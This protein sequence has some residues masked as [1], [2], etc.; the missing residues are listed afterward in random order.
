MKKFFAFSAAFVFSLF[1][2]AC[3]S[4]TSSS[5][6]ISAEDCTLSEEGVKVLRPAGGEVF[7]IGD[8]IEITFVANYKNAAG[9]HVLF[10]ADSSAEGV[11][12]FP[13]SIGDDAPKGTSCTTVKALLSSDAATA[14]EN[15]FVRVYAYNAGRIRGDSKAFTVKE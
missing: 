8:S 6:S 2:A 4:S 9:F 3:D 7:S 11:D 1:F 5:S 12:L 10:K 14:S 13:R 15:A